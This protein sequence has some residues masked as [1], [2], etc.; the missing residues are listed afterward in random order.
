MPSADFDE[1]SRPHTCGEGF[2]INTLGSYR[3]EYCDS[4]YQMN[5]RGECEGKFGLF[6]SG[7]DEVKLSFIDGT[8]PVPNYCCLEWFALPAIQGR[9]STAAWAAKGRISE[10]AIL[11]KNPLWVLFI[12]CH[13]LVSGT[14]IQFLLFKFKMLQ[15]SS[16]TVYR[17]ILQQP[18][19]HLLPCNHLSSLSVLPCLPSFC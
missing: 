2:C 5:R 10:G 14:A 3:C 11:D 8:K 15:R 4:G 13:Y 16:P 18:F 12:L 17:T 9:L 19:N 1:C 7:D 6:T